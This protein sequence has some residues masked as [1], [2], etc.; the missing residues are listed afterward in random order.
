MNA[1]EPSPAVAIAEVIS[2]VIIS[3]RLPGLE[4]AP[5][6]VNCI[7]KLTNIV[8]APIPEIPTIKLL[9][10]RSKLF[11]VFTSVESDVGSSLTTMFPSPSSLNSPEK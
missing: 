11:N 8:N 2:P 9:Y 6:F 1:T 5:N 4:H 3:E 10:L 7:I